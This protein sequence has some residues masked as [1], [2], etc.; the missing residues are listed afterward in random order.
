MKRPNVSAARNWKT[1]AA[2]L[3]VAAVGT[4][5]V[6]HATTYTIGTGGT[7][8]TLEALRNAAVLTDGDVIEFV[9]GAA[10]TQTLAGNFTFA[11]A[12]KLQVINSLADVI[13]ITTSA[14]APSNFMTF[15][16]GGAIDLIVDGGGDNNPGVNIT[17]FTG[18]KDAGGNFFGGAIYSGGDLLFGRTTNFEPVSAADFTIAFS[19]NSLDATT[20]PQAYGGAVYSDG[21]LML[22]GI[23]S[24][25]TENTVT[26]TEDVVGGGALYSKDRLI[27][28][29]SIN[30]FEKNSVTV[31]TTTDEKGTAIGGAIASAADVIFALSINEFKENKTQG[32]YNALGGAVTAMTGLTI[33]ATNS[34]GGLNGFTLF[35]KNEAIG[36]STDAYAQGGAVYVDGA[37]AQDVNVNV[38]GYTYLDSGNLTFSNQFIENKAYASDGTNTLENSRSAGGAM[39][40]GSDKNR[41][42]QTQATLANTYFSGNATI[43]GQFATGGAIDITGDLT[44]AGVNYFKGNSTKTIKLEISGSDAHGGAMA[45]DGSLNISGYNTFEANRVDGAF[46]AYGGA[47]SVT[48]QQ[49]A[50]VSITD[51]YQFIGNAVTVD[52]RYFDEAGS[53]RRGYAEGGAIDFGNAQTVTIIGHAS[54]PIIGDEQRG[55]GFFGNSV[56]A[57]IVDATVE[58]SS[59]V[60]GGAISSESNLTIGGTNTFAD[61]KVINVKGNDNFDGAFISNAFGGAIAMNQTSIPN[62]ITGVIPVVLKIDGDTRFL[63]NS[64]TAS[65]DYSSAYG[66]AIAFNS[67]LST[68]KITDAQ[69]VGNSVAAKVG[70]TESFAHGGAIYTQGDLTVTALN[71]DVDFTSNTANSKPNDIHLALFQKPDNSWVAPTLNLDVAEHRTIFLDGGVTGTGDVE[72]NESR[73]GGLKQSTY[74][75]VNFDKNGTTD[76]AGNLRVHSGSTIQTAVVAGTAGGYRSNVVAHKDADNKNGLAEIANNVTWTVDTS[77]VANGFRG[78]VLV[79]EAGWTVSASSPA[80]ADGRA[81]AQ[82]ALDRGNTMY[83]GLLTAQGNAVGAN[84]EPANLGVDT[85]KVHVADTFVDS[86]LMHDATTIRTASDSRIDHNFNRFRESQRGVVM[87]Q[88]GC[89][90]GASLWGNF[91]G[92]STEIEA[93]HY[94]SG[95]GA[96]FEKA[97]VSSS[98]LQVGADLFA[99]RR[100][101]LGVVIG[102]EKANYRLGRFDEVKSDDYYFGLYGARRYASGIDVR[103]VLGFGYQKY[104]MQRL[105]Q[106][107]LA[108]DRGVYNA[109]FSGQT[110][111]TTL[112]IGRRF[113]QRSSQLSFRPVLGLDVYNNAIG[114]ATEFSG[115]ANE[116]LTYN[117]MS[118]TQT[119]I[120]AGSDV[121][122]LGD[123]LNLSGGMYYLYDMSPNGDTLR[124]WASR[125]GASNVVLGSDLG[126]SVLRF[127]F[128]TNYF[129]N[130]AKTVSLFADYSGDYFAD[131]AGKPMGHTAI[132]GAQVRF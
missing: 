10:A 132:A 58:Q 123:W 121:Q 68:G 7:H 76:I 69:F 70:G 98:G 82:A 6:T 26:S 120:R 72:I 65:G 39:W 41:A 17:G 52:A 55:P 11:T 37:G 49:P 81:Q 16:A 79:G 62:P 95:A 124:G 101:Q 66:G 61:N 63:N 48:S 29:A 118:L 109:R 94:L 28:S 96:T 130:H 84:V 60:R 5:G 114:G 108:V 102:A 107:G 24:T 87:G 51:M 92:R 2:G 59:V 38:I 99:T 54:T 80:G 19:K 119:F 85:T 3:L 75:T 83:F 125:G 18:T 93:K 13:E 113:S 50:T 67:M 44:L 89:K 64:V 57:K 47:I 36:T 77:P 105:Q 31:T 86:L 23:K 126:R 73:D 128:G 116:G 45:V 4:V 8:A 33:N 21:I 111:E 43:A 104:A 1:V 100:S 106:L 71:R 129:L 122:W 115:T 9:T 127:Q 97:K 91:V 25:F 53:P 22:S 103:G 42:K 117:G 56:E 131:R 88:S 74:G 34:V 112:E 20:A 30:T 32:S 12:T 110:F 35:E 15:T 27:L 14:T 40:I 46:R 78:S 90:L